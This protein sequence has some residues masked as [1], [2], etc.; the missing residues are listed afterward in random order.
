V[1]AGTRTDPSRQ[2]KE[3]ISTASSDWLDGS[4]HNRL[5]VEYSAYQKSK[6]TTSLLQNPSISGCWV[7]RAKVRMLPRAK[8][9]RNGRRACEHAHFVRSVVFMQQQITSQDKIRT[10]GGKHYQHGHPRSSDQI[11]RISQTQTS[12]STSTRNSNGFCAA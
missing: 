4:Y 8:M 9:A 3:L 2:K 12:T 5:P 11:S 7:R 1:D 6:A 10:R